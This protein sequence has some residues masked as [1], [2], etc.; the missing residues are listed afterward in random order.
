MN[1]NEYLRKTFHLFGLVIP[2]FYW[3]WPREETF[4]LLFSLFMALIFGLE[5]TRLKIRAVRR[6]YLQFFGVML[7]PGEFDRPSGAFAYAI[8]ATLTIFL[9][10]KDIAIA[11]L[12][13]LAVA[14]PG[15]AYI[16]QRYGRVKLVGKTLEGSLTFFLLAWL[17]LVLYFG[18][19]SYRHLLPAFLGTIVELL[20]FPWNDNVSIPLVIGLTYYFIL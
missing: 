8:G 19:L 3:W 16:G 11:G 10:P 1:R 7:R 9:F 20:P 6:L 5:V 13:V 17:V 15:A 12:L 14:D 4:I 2:F 18:S